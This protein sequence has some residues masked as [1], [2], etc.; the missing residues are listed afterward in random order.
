MR[1]T[2]AAG[3]R[4]VHE[5]DNFGR[6]ATCWCQLSAV[7]MTANS[8]YHC[9]T[10]SS[11][12]CR[13]LVP[14]LRGRPSSDCCFSYSEA[15]TIAFFWLLS[16]AIC[17]LLDV[18]ACCCRP[19]FVDWPVFIHRHPPPCLF[20]VPQSDTAANAPTVCTFPGVMQQLTLQLFVRSQE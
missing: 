15:G 7:V 19:P 14:A 6:L 5:S 2:E 1:L 8:L 9:C 20:R 4:V 3:A 10:F 13:L 11:G 16:A 12:P 18:A 17:W